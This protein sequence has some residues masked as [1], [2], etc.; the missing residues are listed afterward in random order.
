MGIPAACT[1]CIRGY[2]LV[3]ARVRHP[4]LR[5]KGAQDCLV[6][7]H[8]FLHPDVLSVARVLCHRVQIVLGGDMTRQMQFLLNFGRIAAGYALKSEE[9]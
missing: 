7:S 5:P 3:S 9:S 8:L 6:Y 4:P 1:Q 2:L